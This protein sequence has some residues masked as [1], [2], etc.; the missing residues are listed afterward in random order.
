MKRTD[1]PQALADVLAPY[2]KVL[3]LTHNNPDPDAIASAAGMKALVAA[4]SGVSST[5]AFAGFLT[6]AENKEM[7][8]RLHMPIQNVDEIN[9]KSFRAVILV[10]TQPAS[11]NNSLA[12]GQTA[13]AVIDH[14]SL[15]KATLACPYAIVDRKVGATSTL[16]Y[17]MLQTAGVK[18]PPVLASALFLG[19]KTDTQDLGRDAGDR[20]MAA[21]KELFPLVQH[22]IVAQITHPRLSGD[23]YRVIH[24]A[25]E[26]A[27]VC[28]DC[29][30]VPVGEVTTPEFVSEVADYLVAYKGMRWAIVTG[31]FG[32]N[33][34]FSIRTL[35]ARKDAGRLLRRAI[36]TLGVAGG[37]QKMAGGVLPL[38]DVAPEKR[39]SAQA[40]VLSKLFEAL[41]ANTADSIPL[42]VNDSRQ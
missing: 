1:E 38:A 6:R 29:V 34:Y 23:Y 11:G 35:T 4:V 39:E 3:I 28:G 14:H 7:V 27:V 22:R 41:G 16:V 19:I 21:Y 13:V 32:E 26:A 25:I 42:L 10:D 33:L 18:I 24:R 9:V 30:Y 20:D 40:R 31:H 8:A 37:H 17:E 2:R 15:R 12:K 5:A 36:G